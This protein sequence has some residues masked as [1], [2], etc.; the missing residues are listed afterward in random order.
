MVGSVVHLTKV[1]PVRFRYNF[2]NGRNDCYR[3][4]LLDHS[5]NNWSIADRYY[6]NS[7]VLQAN[8]KY[9]FRCT[10]HKSP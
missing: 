9:P 2:G 4:Q 8:G 3:R 1:T 10:Y 7:A 6:L 5:L